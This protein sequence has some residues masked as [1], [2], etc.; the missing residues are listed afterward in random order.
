MSSVVISN[1][2]IF[3]QSIKN[4]E[5]NKVILPFNVNKEQEKRDKDYEEIELCGLVSNICV[6]SNVFYF[7]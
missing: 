5:Q 3:N 1:R 4:I 6:L 2:S 7:S